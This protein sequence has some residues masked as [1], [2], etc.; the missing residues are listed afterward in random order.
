[1]RALRFLGAVA[2]CLLLSG[3]GTIKTLHKDAKYECHEDMFYSGTR[4]GPM[5]LQ[6]ILDTP[7]SLVADTLVLPY[8][9]PRSIWNYHHRSASFWNEEMCLRDSDHGAKPV[10]QL[11]Y[12]P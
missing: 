1:M 2:F 6:K 11:S 7:F 4:V 10:K 5:S 12:T 3:C 8:T 9:I